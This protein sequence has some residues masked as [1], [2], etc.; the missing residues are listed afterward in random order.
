MK[1]ILYA[2]VTIAFGAIL[3][4]SAG[5]SDL[6]W[7][8]TYLL[9]L[10]AVGLAL[11]RFIDPGLLKERVRPGPGGVD[12]ALRWVASP[13]LLIHL[14]IAGL[15]AR[16]GWSTVPPAVRAAAY[17]GFVSALLFATWAIVVNRFFSPVVRIQSERG[18]QVVTA[19]PYRWIRHPGYAATVLGF[20]WGG[21]V[22]GSWWAVVPMLPVVALI[23]RRTVIEDRFLLEHLPGYRAYASRVR[24]RLLPGVW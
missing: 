24:W 4:L 16:W 18:H 21:L 12:R 8:W 13:F 1:L 5:R 11:G 14:V 2:S 7:F 6:P 19:G 23:L 15:D 17:G 9:T 10:P 20:P 22:L 3:F